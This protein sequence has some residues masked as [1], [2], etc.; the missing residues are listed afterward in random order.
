[1]VSLETASGKG[2]VQV[3][4]GDWHPGW[5]VDPNYET[6]NTSPGDGKISGA[7]EVYEISLAIPCDYRHKT[8]KYKVT[9]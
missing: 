9:K 8:R 5:G 1:M 2:F 6:F 3:I 4:G 7:V